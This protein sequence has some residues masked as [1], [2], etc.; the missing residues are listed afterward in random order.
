MTVLFSD[1]TNFNSD[2]SNWDVGRVTNMKWMFSYASSFNS[3]ISNWNVSSVT[4]MYDMFARASHFNSNISNWNVGRVADMR[5]MFYGDE[6]QRFNQNLCPWGS[7]LSSAFNYGSS[8]EKMFFNS[9]C[10]NR[11]S[12]T[13]RTGPWCKATCP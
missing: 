9:G 6:A 5:F 8:A 4:N 2:I 12:P 1:K 11:N 10:P 7:K 13:G 3:D